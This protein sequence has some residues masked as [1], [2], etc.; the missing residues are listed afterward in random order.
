MLVSGL[1]RSPMCPVWTPLPLAEEEG[2]EPPMR[3]S[4]H[5]DLASRRLQP[6]GHS[7]ICQLHSSFC[8]PLISCGSA[9]DNLD[10]PAR[11]EPAYTELQSVG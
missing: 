1:I 3:V 2:F 8:Q 7:S 6:L 9:V 5:N 10:A 11:L 4:P